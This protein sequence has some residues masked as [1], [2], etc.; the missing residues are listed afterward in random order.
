MSIRFPVGV[1]ALALAL[2]A[3]GFN[4]SRVS[5]GPDGGQIDGRS[6]DGAVSADGRFVAFTTVVPLVPGDRNTLEDVYLHDRQTGELVYVSASLDGLGGDRASTSPDISDSGN[7]VVFASSASNLVRDDT[8]QRTDVFL[9]DRRS[10]GLIRISTAADGGEANASSSSPRISADGRIVAFVSQANNLVTGDSNGQQDVF[11]HSVALGGNRRVSVLSDGR[12]TNGPSGSPSLAADGLKVAF[13]SLAANLNPTGGGELQQIYTHDVLL[14]ETSHV[15]LPSDT[16]ERSDIFGEPVLSPDGGWIAFVRTRDGGAGRSDIF[17]QN[18]DTGK[19]TLV[20]DPRGEPEA[21]FHTGGAVSQDGEIVL[22]D[23]LAEN[24]IAGDANGENDVFRFNRQAGES[25]R[26]SGPGP[27]AGGNGE[28]VV[29]DMSPDGRFAL[30][31]SAASNLVP[32]DTNGADDIFLNDLTGFLIDSATTGSWFDESQDGH[33][34]I[35]EY[36][37]D[38][39]MLFYWFTFTPGGDR[40]WIFGVL[41]VNGSVAEGQAFRQLGDGARFP[42]AIEP[43]NIDTVAWG[44]I[45]FE[46]SGCESG[47]VSWDATPPFQDGTMNL[48]RLTLIPGLP[49]P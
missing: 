19:S 24:L 30:F 9:F 25:I 35:I 37:G 39:R 26:V 20:T 44:T 11:I 29:L 43:S 34:F 7:H 15:E 32:G 1:I 10:G 2:P 38:D 17:L 16:I 8:N 12:Q 14:R 33:G 36:L 13:A 21:G 40:E 41:D 4:V 3:H 46:F 31:Q 45:R 28:S 48:S 23:S 6:R 18:L 49:C 47:T 42:P 22:F 5:V 27:N